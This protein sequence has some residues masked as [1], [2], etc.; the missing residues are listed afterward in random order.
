MSTTAV[1]L[2]DA[3]GPPLWRRQVRALVG[4]ELKK[5]FSIARS[6]WLFFLAFAPTFIITA[7]A[8]HDKRCDLAK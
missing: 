4:V 2:P 7:H 3:S 6:F 5:G 1:A 8:L